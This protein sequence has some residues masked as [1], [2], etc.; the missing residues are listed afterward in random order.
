MASQKRKVRFQE[1]CEEEPP[2]QKQKQHTIESDDEEEGESS[3]KS[4]KEDEGERLHEDD[5]EGQEEETIRF[6]GDIAVTP[7]NLRDEMEEG[8]CN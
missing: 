5:I 1:P 6:D 4:D 2:L 3:K 8:Q 7:F